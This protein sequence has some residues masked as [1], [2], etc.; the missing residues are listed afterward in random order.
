MASTIVLENGIVRTC[1]ARGHTVS[2]L[3]TAGNRIGVPGH[4]ASPERI[5][6]RGRCVVPGFSDS[7]VHFPTWS[8]VQ[9][10]TR[11]EDARSPE[12]VIARIA[13]AAGGAA[14]GTWVRGYGWREGDWGEARI[15]PA[16][17]D[18][19]DRAT[20]D[21]PVILTSRDYHS[22]WVNA[23]ALARANGDLAVP[24]GVVDLTPSG[25]PLGVLREAA[26]W[27]FRDKVARPSRQELLDATRDGIRLAHS[28]GVTAVH[29]KDGWLG[30]LPIWE[31]LR[32]AGELGLRV[33]QSLPPE[34]LDDLA[35]LGIAS[36][37]GDDWLSIGYIKMFQDGA[38]GSGTA[39]LADGSGVTITPPEQLREWVLR[40]AELGF[41]VAIHAIGD[42][43]NQQVLDVLEGTRD[44]WAPRGLRQ[45][46][47][48]GQLLRREDVDRFAA[49]GIALSVQFSHVAMDRDI[50]DDAW[51]GMTDRMYL[52]K[53]LQEAGVRLCN[54]SDAPIDELDPLRGI[55]VA[56][57]RSDD[58]RGAWHPEQRLSAEDALWATTVNPAWLARDEHRRGRLQPDHLADLVV[59]DRDPVTC[60]PDELEDVHVVATMVDGAWVHNPPPWD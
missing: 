18:Q 4:G 26:A 53:S 45:R 35:S 55:R 34:Q 1:T 54:G 42:L 56:V 20:G 32:A 2:H 51:A 12:E 47:E 5:D 16:L 58:G 52:F 8:L 40:A 46:I 60:P 24:G 21:V 19:F 14:P 44:A 30:A 6:L 27:T 50:A 23:A 57:Q 22:V 11:L 25:E 29:D 43:A 37:F 33:W 7:H 10:Q 59:L 48:H 15:T 41:P 3:E 31:R 28:R 39:L 38:L 13:S 49:L 36:G 17:R 9:R